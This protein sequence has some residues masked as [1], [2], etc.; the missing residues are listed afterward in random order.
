VKAPGCEGSGPD[1][2]GR[3][4]EDGKERLRA[5]QRSLEGSRLQLGV[6]EIGQG[7]AHGAQRRLDVSLAGWVEG[8]RHKGASVTAMKF[9]SAV[10][11]GRRSKGSV[12]GGEGP[13][14]RLWGAMTP[15]Y[16]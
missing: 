5:Q 14:D 11:L 13:G 1:G 2:S 3:G 4:G 8:S 6:K 10:A 9:R 12:G 15:L 7:R 16:A